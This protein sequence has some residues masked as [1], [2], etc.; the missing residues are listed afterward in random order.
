MDGD[1]VTRHPEKMAVENVNVEK[2]RAPAGG[3]IL[4]KRCRKVSLPLAGQPFKGELG[5]LILESTCRE[6]WQAWREEGTRI[7]RSLILDFTIEAHADEYD[8][9]MKEFLRLEGG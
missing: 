2:S 9:R 1:R 3:E 8:R 6:C 5:A 4:C 7:I